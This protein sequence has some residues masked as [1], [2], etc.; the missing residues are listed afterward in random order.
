[1]P[2]L[3]IWDLLM[4]I[5][6]AQ[7]TVMAFVFWIRRNTHISAKFLSVIFFVLAFSILGTL[8]SEKPPDPVTSLHI[9][10]MRYVPFWPFMLVGPSLLFIVQS[11]VD[12]SFKF[13]RRKK[14]HYIAIV[15]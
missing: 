5:G 3:N 12:R 15:Y 14:L 10:L 11:Q 6:I 9:W 8:I 1:M 7:G 4:V 13:D 2:L